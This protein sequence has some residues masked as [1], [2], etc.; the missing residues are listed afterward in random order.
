MPED[1]PVGST[2]TKRKFITILREAL[3]A[4]SEAR[5]FATE[6]GFQGALIHELSKRLTQAQF[7]DDPVV[8]Q[9]YQKT[10]PF[11]GLT[12][13]PD[14]IIH[15]PFDRKKTASRKEGNFVAIELKVRASSADAADDFMSLKLLHEVIHYSMTIFVNIDA[16][17]THARLCPAAIAAH[18]VCFAVRLQNGKPIV[19]GQTCI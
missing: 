5:F 7:P 4:I 10:L 2:V 9:E 16:Q 17:E 6:R 12:I 3:G 11:H 15:V 18:T 19:L 14:L 1:M 8:E 13:R